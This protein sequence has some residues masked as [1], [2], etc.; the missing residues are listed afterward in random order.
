MNDL[1]NEVKEI[2]KGSFSIVYRAINIKTKKPVAIKKIPIRFLD[3][4]NDRILAELEIISKLKHV[5]ILEFNEIYQSKN[6]IYISSELCDYTLTKIINTRLSEQDIFN[7][8]TQIINGMKYLYDRK[9]FHRDIKPENILV[10][11]DIIKIADF[12]FAKRVEDHNN[13][14]E[15]ICGSPLYMAPEIILNKPYTN[16]SDIWSLGIILYQMMYKT[17][18]FGNVYSVVQLIKNFDSK[19]K[20]NYPG[21]NYSEELID[22]VT[23]MLIYDPNNRISWEKLFNHCWL[24]KKIQINVTNQSIIK[25]DDILDENILFESHTSIKCSSEIND[26]NKDSYYEDYNYNHKSKPIKIE[27]KKNNSNIIDS[28]SKSPDYGLQKTDSLKIQIAD[29]QININKDHFGESCIQSLNAQNCT[30]PPANK[31]IMNN[32]HQNEEYE[33]ETYLG[34]P[35][36]FIK[37]SFKFFSL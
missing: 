25:S 5:N 4:Y 34:N 7:I 36:A 9:I 28:C 1:Y 10:K 12:G 13:V 35:W 8:Y 32:S 23:Q 21:K 27:R 20:I 37:R 18:P 22:F 11:D 6:N 26:S 3:K 2:G 15:T 33:S 29:K 24:V 31:T 17:H 19:T 30:Y 14:M 16:K